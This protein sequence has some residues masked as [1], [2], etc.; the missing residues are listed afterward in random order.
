MMITPENSILV[1]FVLP[2]IGAI[3]IGFSNR[4]PN[5]RETV[6]LITAVLTFC[7]IFLLLTP[8][9]AGAR[10]EVLLFTLFPGVEVKFIIEPLGI[11]FACIASS[12]WIITTIYS[13][14][15]MRAHHEKNQTRFYMAFAVAISC[16]IGI[17]FSGNVITLFIFYELL[18]L[19]TYPLVTHA[20]TDDAK[21]GGRVYLG[22]LLTTS[23][24]FFL[25]A[26]IWTLH[27]AGTLDFTVGGI[28][29]DKTSNT[30]LGVIL[31]L[32][33]F[34]IGK[35][36]LMPFHRWLPAAMIAPTPVSALLHAVAVVKAGVFSVLKISLFIFGFDTLEGLDM[37]QFLMYLAAAT[38]LIASIVAMRQDN[39][40]RRLAYSTIS[41]LS[42]IVLGAMLATRL[43]FIGGGMHIAT[44]AFGKITLFFCAGSIL[45]ATHKTEI[46]QMR[47]LGRDMPFTM[48]AFLI[49][50]LS[51]IGL[52]PFGGL[53]SKWYLALGALDAD[54]ILMLAVLMV[55]SILNVAYLLPIAI[56]GFFSDPDSSV[57]N[58]E[59]DKVPVKLHEAPPSCV[60]AQSFTATGTL[61]L[62]FYSEPIYL[63]LN[64]IFIH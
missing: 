8:V 57:N 60:A 63:L 50:S 39:L 38:I 28:L 51:V 33:M 26:I 9:Y 52:P 35:A 55:S 42:Y 54:E 46:S 17:S 40:K 32:Y 59:L 56:R 30:V 18:S 5:L 10:P 45:V 43:G 31:L 4:W 44:H 15:Y 48:A 24:M 61:V 27:I 22:I 34:G 13:I 23:I 7:V 12:L 58:G 62:F 14:G 29:S 2:L 16:A 37:T 41:Q 3:G 47:G 11:L 19:S 64:S 20:G 36:A 49:G 21:K 1:A 53:W 25:P 6:T